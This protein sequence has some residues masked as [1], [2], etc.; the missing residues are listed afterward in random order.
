[1]EQQIHLTKREIDVVSLLLEGKTRTEI[2]KTL[3]I[4]IGTVNTHLESIYS[5][6]DVHNRVQSFRKATHLSLIAREII[7]PGHDR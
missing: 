4:N 3:G 5:K 6:L 2:G 1:M 7:K